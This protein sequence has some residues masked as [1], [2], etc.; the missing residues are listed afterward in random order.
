M[1]NTINNNN[2][3]NNKIKCKKNLKRKNLECLNKF[4]ML[5]ITS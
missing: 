1:N 2:N 3:N 5:N 4:N